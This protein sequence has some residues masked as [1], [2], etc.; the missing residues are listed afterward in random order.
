MKKNFYY[1][2]TFAVFLI[3]IFSGC[4]T[5]KFS[6]IEGVYDEKGLTK[7]YNRSIPVE[8]QS[9]IVIVDRYFAIKQITGAKGSLIKMGNTGIYFNSI[10]ILPPGEYEFEISYFEMIGTYDYIEYTE[11]K[12]FQL[13]EGQFYF[14]NGSREGAVLSDLKNSPK[15]FVHGNNTNIT[16][17]MP[18]EKIITDMVAIIRGKFPNFNPSLELSADNYY[19]RGVFYNMVFKDQ[20]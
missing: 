7:Y 6:V 19:W 8:D 2:I 20:E 13:Y 14:L 1:Q 5:F 3:L 15:I 12:R 16:A 4:S 10:I 9:Y 11:K 18:T 17:I